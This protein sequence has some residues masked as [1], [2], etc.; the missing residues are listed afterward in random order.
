MQRCSLDTLFFYLYIYKIFEILKCI[1]ILGKFEL[2]NQIW[3]YRSNSFRPCKEQSD[4]ADFIW[5]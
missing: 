2:T 4:E 3:F 1:Y 5:Y